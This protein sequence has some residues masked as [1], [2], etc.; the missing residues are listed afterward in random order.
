MSS[1]D[2]DMARFLVGGDIDEVFVQGAAW[3]PEASA[4]NDLDT[5]ITLLKFKNGAFGTI[6]NSRVCSFGYDQRVEVF[7]AKGALQGQNRSPN[8]V[9]RSDANGIVGGRRRFFFWGG[10][11]KPLCQN[12]S[13]RVNLS[14]VCCLFSCF[15]FWR[16]CHLYLVSFFSKQRMT[17]PV[18]YNNS[19]YYIQ[20]FPTPSSWTVT[21][22]RT[23]E[24]F[25]RL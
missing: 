15:F 9:V 19:T 21:A 2:F 13:D 4:A 25:V 22:M 23:W 20:P 8:T 14:L 6:E 3:G 1:H 11:A 17:C 18:T 7:G 12:R 16:T 10:K 24:L 5:Q